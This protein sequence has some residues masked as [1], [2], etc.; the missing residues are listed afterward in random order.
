MHTGGWQVGAQYSDPLWHNLF[1]LT[2][3][4]PGSDLAAVSYSQAP[5]AAQQGICVAN[6]SLA[7]MTH[8]RPEQN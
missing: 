8:G 4:F 6:H 2:V 1:V 7:L 5:P 3:H